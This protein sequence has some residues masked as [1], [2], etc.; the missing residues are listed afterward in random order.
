MFSVSSGD[1][2]CCSGF[3][4]VMRK[5]VFQ[6]FLDDMF[7]CAEIFCFVFDKTV[8]FNFF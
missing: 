2:N 3:A 4:R 7:F 1:E 8:F 5:K 6:F